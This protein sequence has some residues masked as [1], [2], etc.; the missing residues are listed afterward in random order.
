[1]QVAAPEIIVGR[2]QA[3]LEIDATLEI[4]RSLDTSVPLHIALAAV[5]EDRSGALSYWA[6]RHPAGEPDF[7][8]RDNFILEVPAPP[9]AVGESSIGK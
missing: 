5:V 2:K 9:L 3:A 6:L 4:P 7:H 8:H 1:V